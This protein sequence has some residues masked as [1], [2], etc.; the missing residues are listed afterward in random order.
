MCMCC[1]NRWGRV[2]VGNWITVWWDRTE[3]GKS[4]GVW[5]DRTFFGEGSEEVS[6]PFLVGSFASPAASLVC[7]R[8]R[9][10]AIFKKVCVLK[11]VARGGREGRVEGDL[12]FRLWFS[13]GG[14]G[15]A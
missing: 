9:V 7:T 8:E 11:S 13:S 2:E 1:R 6:D 3:G 5:W 15:Q 4:C 12:V 14:R 10:L